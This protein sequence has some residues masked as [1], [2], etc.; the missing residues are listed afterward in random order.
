LVETIKALCAVLTMMNRCIEH[1]KPS[2]LY[3]FF[4]ARVSEE[5]GGFTI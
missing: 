2:H 4:L 1:S 3:F 5:K